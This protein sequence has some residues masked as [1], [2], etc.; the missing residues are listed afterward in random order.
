MNVGVKQ[1]LAIEA[2]EA[3]YCCASHSF[4]APLRYVISHA[5]RPQFFTQETHR[6]RTKRVSSRMG[7]LQG[8]SKTNFSL[9][10]RR[11]NVEHTFQWQGQRHKRCCGAPSQKIIVPQPDVSQYAGQRRQEFPLGVLLISYVRAM[12]KTSSSMLTI[13]CTGD[14]LNAHR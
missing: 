10:R 8:A 4:T 13:Y 7:Y 3:T 14:A 2:N 1:A 11:A 9:D 6:T 12:A 5:R